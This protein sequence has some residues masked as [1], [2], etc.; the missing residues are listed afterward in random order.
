[1]HKREY[2]LVRTIDLKFIDQNIEFSGE[3][4]STNNYSITDYGFVWQADHAQSNVATSN[5][6]SHGTTAE[7]KKFKSTI[8]LSSIGPNRIY[9][10]RTYV[11]G[12]NTTVYGQWI[13]FKK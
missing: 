5:V 10:M 9:Y 6:I 8:P 2:P 4:L 13:G 1:M 11:Q 12:N 7:R 3:I